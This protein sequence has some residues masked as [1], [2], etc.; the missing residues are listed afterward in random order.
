MTKMNLNSDY[1]LDDIN[2]DD[3]QTRKASDMNELK[4]MTI[5][6]IMEASNKKIMEKKHLNGQPEENESEY[7]M[8]DYSSNESSN[9]ND[10]DTHYGDEDENKPLFGGLWSKGVSAENTNSAG[11]LFPTLKFSA[12]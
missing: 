10:Y 3:E 2:E 11:S 5:V 7:E 12:K 6:E 9:D 1:L 8:T 4:K